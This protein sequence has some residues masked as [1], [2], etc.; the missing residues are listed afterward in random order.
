MDLREIF[1]PAA[2]AANWTEVAS[3]QIPYLGATLFPARKK[4]DDGGKEVPP[5]PPLRL[6]D[7]R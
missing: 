1:T 3:N 4:A 2:V 7:G 5:S 6:L